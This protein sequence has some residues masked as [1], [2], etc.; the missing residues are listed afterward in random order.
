M[1]MGS[2]SQMTALSIEPQTFTL[3]SGGVQL[4]CHASSQNGPWT[5]DVVFSS[6]NR[7]IAYFTDPGQ[8]GMTLSQVKTHVDSGTGT[9]TVYPGGYQST[10][11][12][13]T[14][15]VST[16]DANMTAE[17]TAILKAIGG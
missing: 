3:A 2:S 11:Q 6:N 14:I 5:G 8:P 4:T 16:L 7:G 12:R 17:C 9:V 10:E 15:R 13:T 1:V